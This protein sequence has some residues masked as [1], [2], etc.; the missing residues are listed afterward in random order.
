VTILVYKSAKFLPKH[1][2]EPLLNGE[3]IMSIEGFLS[4]YFQR[5]GLNA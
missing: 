5:S 3:K 4:A 2:L 1:D